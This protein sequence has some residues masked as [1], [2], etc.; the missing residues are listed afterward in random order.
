[1]AA[2][3][4]G[5]RG[6]IVLLR[7]TVGGQAFCTAHK[8]QTVYHGPVVYAEDPYRRL[9]RAS[10][11]FELLLLLVF[12]KDAGH[13]AQREYRFAVW[14]EQEPAEDRVD[15]DV[16]PALVDAMWRPR[17]EPEG[18]GFLS[19][20]AEGWSAVEELDD[21]RSSRAGVRVEALPA[22][23]GIGNP[24]VAP[25][26][27]DFNRLPEDLREAATAYAT[28]EALREAVERTDAAGRATA[29][30]AWHAE[31][32][33]RSFCSTFG[34]DIA[35]VA[36]NENGFVVITAERSSGCGGDLA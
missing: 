10:S 8:S 22:F 12:L 3:Q 6:G 31:P 16:S 28:V 7:N 5:P 25:R 26:R 9:E 4:V 15:L 34:D 29:A 17:E 33:V 18:S 2:E 30:A 11:D 14:A 27:Y 20:G 23:A 13:R 32:I 36:V 35:G 21:R 1:M 24:T 19:A